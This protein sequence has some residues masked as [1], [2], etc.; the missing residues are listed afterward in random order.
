[1]DERRIGEKAIPDNLKHILNE[2]QLMMLG[3]MER[4][5]WEL[6]FIRRPLFM[7]VVPVLIHLDSQRIAVM[8]NEGILNIES[9]IKIREQAAENK[10]AVN[11]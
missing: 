4:F 5:G 11:R 1:M 6:K 8:E 3:R 7:D 10:S 9:D 2:T